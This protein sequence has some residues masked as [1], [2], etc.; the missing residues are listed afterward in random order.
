MLAVSTASLSFEGTKGDA[1]PLPQTFKIRNSGEETLHYQIKDNRGWISVSPESGDSE[2]EW[3]EIEVAVDI[4]SVSR[5]SYKGQVTITA[6]IAS[7]SPQVITVHLTVYGPEIRLNKSSLSFRAEAGGPNP[8]SQGFKIKNSG[9][10]TLKYQISTDKEWISVSPASGN[11]SGE[12][13]SIEVA[14][15]ISHLT[16]GSNQAQI[17]ITAPDS[18]N[19]PQS[20]NVSLRIQFPPLFPPSNFRGEKKKNRSLSQ[21][22]YINV[23]TWEVNPQNKF[24]QKY[25]IYLL[26]DGGRTLIGETDA[27]TFQYWHRK[28]E[29]ESV[30]RYEL[31]AQD[32][33]GRESDPAVIEVR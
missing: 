29:R 4:S 10:G 17:I 22:E 1:N 8:P 28:V 20:L 19:S 25:K 7:N 24:I 30:Y 5:G 27:Q 31:R 9:E 32:E 21:I 11:S 6:E 14:V 2:G 12:W 26:E 13:D 18:S 15:D 33:F 23:L 3:D 16:E